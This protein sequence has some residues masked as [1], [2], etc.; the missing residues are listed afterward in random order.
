MKKIFV[1][2]LS[3]LLLVSLASV[4]AAEAGP[5]A[6]PQEKEAFSWAYL[7]TIAGAAAATLLIVQFAKAPLDKVWK[8]PTRWLVYLVALGILLLATA[9]TEGLSLQRLP[10]VMLN[11]FLAAL[12]AYGSYEITFAQREQKAAD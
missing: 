4:A 6:I 1:V 5:S 8:L 10:L 11:A 12:S 7:A 9:F 3:L 2:F